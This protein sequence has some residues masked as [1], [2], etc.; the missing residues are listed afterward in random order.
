MLLISPG[1]GFPADCI[2]TGGNPLN[3]SG[4]KI[5]YIHVQ[6]IHDVNPQ[7]MSPVKDRLPLCS[8]FKDAL[9]SPVRKALIAFWGSEEIIDQPEIIADIGAGA[10][11]RIKRI[12]PKSLSEIARTLSSL[13]YIPSSHQWLQ[14]GK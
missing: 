14:K 2:G 13:G 4:T 10:V 8:P 7:D 12:G 1:S 3:H 9:P 6:E 11:S 5:L